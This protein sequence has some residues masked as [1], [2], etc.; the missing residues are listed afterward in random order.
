MAPA[1]ELRDGLRRT[2]EWYREQ[3]GGKAG[4]GNLDHLG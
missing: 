2:L 4:A 3:P 1:V